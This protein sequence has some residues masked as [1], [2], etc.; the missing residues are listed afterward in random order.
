VPSKQGCE[1]A[2]LSHIE[3]EMQ[4]KSPLIGSKPGFFGSFFKKL[5]FA[6]PYKSRVLQQHSKTFKKT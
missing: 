3:E 5:V 4:K 2:E 1:E 6:N